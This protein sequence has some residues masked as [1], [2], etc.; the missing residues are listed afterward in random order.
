MTN[1][2]NLIV[3]FF[4]GIGSLTVG[5]FAGVL[6]FGGRI[7]IR[8]GKV[9]DDLG[10]NQ[11][12]STELAETAG[13]EERLKAAAAV[14]LSWAWDSAEGNMLEVRTVLS[15]VLEELYPGEHR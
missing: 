3:M 7:N 4:A 1:S 13:R 6:I 12:L 14:A 8:L 15:D 5:A 11:I 9:E 10:Q 2:V